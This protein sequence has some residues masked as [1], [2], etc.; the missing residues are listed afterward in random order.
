MST[1]GSTAIKRA[2]ADRGEHQGRRAAGQQDLPALRRLGPGG[3]RFRR[4][5]RGLERSHGPDQPVAALR[6]GLYESAEALIAPGVNEAAAQFVEAAG[7]G[8][9]GDHGVRPQAG[10]QLLAQHDLA[11]ALCHQQEH[12]HD[13]RIQPLAPA[14]AGNE[15]GQRLDP[16]RIQPEAMRKG[17]HGNIGT[18][19]GFD[20]DDPDPSGSHWRSFR[21]SGLGRFCQRAPAAYLVAS[22]RKGKGR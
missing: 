22:T 1:K 6:Y 2:D 20:Q 8:V 15:P 9:V 10:E 5:F 18:I 4:G 16:Q 19:S 21:N 14:R 3:S 7:Q 11:G 13:L 12:V 17:V